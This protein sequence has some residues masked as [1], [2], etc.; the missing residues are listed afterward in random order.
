MR[1]FNGFDNLPKFSG[2]VVTVGSYDGVHRGHRVLI[3]MVTGLARRSGGESVVITFSPHPREILDPEGVK[4][5]NTPC[6]KAALLEKAGVDNLIIIPF[7]R[8]FSKIS[9]RDFVKDYLVGKVGMIA[10]VAGY[11]HHFG[12]GKEGGPDSMEAL[13]D[14]MGFVFCPVARHDVGDSKVSST[15]IR[16]YIEQGDMAKASELLG[17]D[18]FFNARLSDDARLVIDNPNKLLPPAGEYD[19]KICAD[20]IVTNGRLRMEDPETGKLVA[21]DLSLP[22]DEL[23][24]RDVTVTFVG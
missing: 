19:V 2:A 14:E 16:G 6:E 11:N 13:S 1:I 5:L 3:D 18:Y 9:Y 17:Y 10:F 15:V 20:N 21:C 12:A 24:N 7:T 8:E 4:L 22:L 23:A